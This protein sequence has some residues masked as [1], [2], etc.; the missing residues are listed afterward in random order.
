MSNKILEGAK[1]D[2]VLQNISS[3]T[4]ATS[5][6]SSLSMANYDRVVFHI[7]QGAITSAPVYVVA[8]Y[9]A[10]DAAMGAAVAISGA[11]TTATCTASTP[12]QLE[13]RAD[14]MDMA[15]YP[16]YSYFGIKVVTSGGTSTNVNAVAVRTP[17]RFKQTAEPS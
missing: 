9:Q 5:T 7:S 12:V 3:F 1:I 16:T 4:G 13:V 11:S 15:N 2:T 17:A 8:A 10:T 6:S 14:A